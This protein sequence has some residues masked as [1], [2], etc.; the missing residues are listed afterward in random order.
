MN[1]RIDEINDIK[2]VF[3]EKMSE[4]L[5]TEVDEVNFDTDFRNEIDYFDSLMGYMMITKIEEDY[6]VLIS[7]DDFIAAASLAELYSLIEKD[8]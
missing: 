1:K 2:A 3:L 6:G 7:V 5:E 8:S 4:V